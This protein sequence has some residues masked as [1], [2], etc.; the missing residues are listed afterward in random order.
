VPELAASFEFWLEASHITE[1]VFAPVVV[2]TPT[3]GST[4]TPTPSPTA[5]ATTTP[6]ATGGPTATPTASATPTVTPTATATPT[7][8]ITPTPA[9]LPEWLGVIESNRQVS[10]NWFSVIRASVDGKLNWPVWVTLLEGE[11][12]V[13][14]AS[15]PTGSKPE[16]GPYFCEVSPIIPGTYRVAPQGLDVSVTVTVGP[17]AVAVVRFKKSAVDPAAALSAYSSQ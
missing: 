3:P 17:G 7:P 9:P 12:P 13:W 6:T 8:T 10:G 2:V 14:S 15:C 16:Y 4:S 1:V 11:T 5:T